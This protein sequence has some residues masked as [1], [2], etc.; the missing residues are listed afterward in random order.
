MRKTIIR[1]SVAPRKPIGIIIQN[2]IVVEKAESELSIILE[3]E[4]LLLRQLNTSVKHSSL[5]GFL[6]IVKR[7]NGIP[8]QTIQGLADGLYQIEKSINFN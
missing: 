5:E 1:D 3:N 7:Q 6:T 4:T 2:P 8:V